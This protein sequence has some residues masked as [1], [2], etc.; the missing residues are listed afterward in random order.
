MKF[1]QKPAWLL[2]AA[3]AGCSTIGHER[4]EGWPVLEVVEHYVP[5]A[6]MRDRCAKYVGVGMS[7]LACAEFDLA[8]RRCDLWFSADF[9]PS[10]HVLEHE[11]LHCQGYDHPGE[12]TMRDILAR[13]NARQNAQVGDTQI[14]DRPHFSRRTELAK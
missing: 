11:R 9:P 3:L 14:G 6:A 13:F 4:V 10:P 12:T 1:L 5:N 2:L 8:A 7:P